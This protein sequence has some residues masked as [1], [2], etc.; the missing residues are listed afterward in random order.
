MYKR[1]VVDCAPYE[2]SRIAVIEAVRT[3][4]VAEIVQPA[5]E[6]VLT[7]EE[8]SEIATDKRGIQRQ[9]YLYRTEPAFRKR[10]VRSGGFGCQLRTS[11]A[12]CRELSA[13]VAS[14]LPPSTIITS[15]VDFPARQRQQDIAGSQGF[16]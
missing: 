8:K 11:S 4:T 13:I 10:A 5:A 9:N 1:Q 3:D 14:A 6:L 2:Y 16:V 7:G 15:C 12:R